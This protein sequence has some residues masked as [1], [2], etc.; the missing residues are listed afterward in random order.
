MQFTSRVLADSTLDNGQR[1]V[2]EFQGQAHEFS[3]SWWGLDQG[4]FLQTVHYGT[5]GNDHMQAYSSGNNL[6]YAGDGDDHIIGRTGRDVMYGERGDD[7]ME[8]RDDDDQLWA[9]H[10]N[11]LLLGGNGNDRLFGMTGDDQLVGG[12]GDDVLDG[13]TGNDI[14]TGGAGKDRF[15]WPFLQENPATGS[16]VDIIRDFT[17]GEDTLVF[18]PMLREEGSNLR[19]TLRQ[20]GSQGVLE[21]RNPHEQLVQTIRLENTDLLSVKDDQGTL[22]ETLS[23]QAALQ[24]LIEIGALENHLI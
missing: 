24:R 16:E 5:S 14:M 23:S 3:L 9:G 15:E 8:G 19:F 4:P 7:K 2:R 13:G 17:L 22:I 20:E 11:D 21:L 1:I 18:W 6:F 12:D 10:G